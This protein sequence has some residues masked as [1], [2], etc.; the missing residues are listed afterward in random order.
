MNSAL[1]QSIGEGHDSHY[2]TMEEKRRRKLY[3]RYAAEHNVTLNKGFT[4]ERELWTACEIT[5]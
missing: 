5:V 2:L 4:S 3:N 1:T